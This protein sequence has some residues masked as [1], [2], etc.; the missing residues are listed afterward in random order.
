[1][2]VFSL[3]I[4]KFAKGN[5]S[6]FEIENFEVFL[7]FKYGNKLN[8]YMAA[9]GNISELYILSITLRLTLKFWVFIK[10]ALY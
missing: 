4:V 5:N 9:F 10:N 6:I 2:Q 3:L 7:Y 8:E 1:M